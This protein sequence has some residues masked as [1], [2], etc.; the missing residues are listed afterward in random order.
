MSVWWSWWSWWSWWL[1]V[2][3]DR[4]ADSLSVLLVE[5]SDAHALLIR[6]VLEDLARATRLTVLRSGQAALE[7]IETPGAPVPDLILLDLHLPGADGFE[8]LRA[9]RASEAM[10]FVPTLILSSSEAEDDIQRA[11][12]CGANAFLVKPVGFGAFHRLLERSLDFW[13][14][15]NRC[16]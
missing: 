4:H 14:E 10:R 5:D 2:V 3:V 12:R 13:G 7:L 6:H 15:C 11:Y 8:V 1:G 16:P 9:L